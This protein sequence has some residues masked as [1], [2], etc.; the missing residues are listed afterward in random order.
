VKI[1]PALRR[2]YGV[3]YRQLDHWASNGWIRAESLSGSGHDREFPVSEIAIFKIMATLVL[4]GFRP[5]VAAEVAR[6]AVDKGWNGT[7]RLFRGEI[8]ATGLLSARAS[9]N[10][11][12]TDTE[13]APG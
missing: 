2:E 9:T 4:I 8:T 10:A 13:S 7:L 12:E 3:S 6:S 5:V 1:D 11:L